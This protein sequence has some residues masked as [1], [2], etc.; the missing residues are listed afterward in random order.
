MK[1]F[2]ELE[3]RGLIAQCTDHEKVKDLLNNGKITFYVGFDPT[4]DSLHVGN[5][6]QLIIMSRLQ[7]AGHNPIAILGVGTTMVGD[8][9]GRT[10]MRQML[11]HEQITANAENF[12]GQMRN[13]VDFG[14]G[15]AI[16]VNNADWLMKLN[17][18]D[19]LRDIGKYFSVNRMLTAECFKAR[20]ER[21]LSFIEFN[22]MLMQSYDFLVLNQKYGCVLQC[23][24][25]D[26]W[27]NIIM[28]ADLIRRVEGNDAH[29]LTFTLLTTSD[30]RKMGKTQKGA[31]WLDPKKTSP[32]DFYQYWRNVADDDVVRL[33]KLVTFLPLETIA[34]YEKLE[35]SELNCAK[36]VLAYELTAIVH[37][38]EEAVNAQNA[39]RALFSA[40]SDDSNMPTTSI[41]SADLENMSI[42]DLMVRCKLSKSKGEAR[43]LIDQG[44]VE[45][46]G[47]RVSDSMTMIGETD[48]SNNDLIL[49]KG[50]KTYIKVTLD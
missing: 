1:V 44:G 29:G 4:A 9:T 31:V 48:F 36:E 26:Q 5:L 19:F 35:G 32:Y 28:G 8:P 46:N 14:E 11:S 3:A 15:K 7:K 10:D 40:G 20:L 38:T 24:G 47:T 33:M 27:S 16:M 43:R 23:G 50:K 30:G 37:G 21:G 45:L 18:I 34:S 6:L 22:Y 39:A 49:R 25:D 13:I 2:D 17:Y 12:K 41:T 42:A